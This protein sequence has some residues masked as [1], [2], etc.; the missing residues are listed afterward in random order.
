[1]PIDLTVSVDVGGHRPPAAAA[2][3][4]P[5]EPR[6]KTGL[7]HSHRRSERRV[8]PKPA[9]QRIARRGTAPSSKRTVAGFDM[10]RR[11][12]DRPGRAA[13]LRAVMPR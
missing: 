8:H 2:A 9:L 12:D 4:V 6:L 1:M 5:V 3:D 10:A 11:K 7:R 13:A